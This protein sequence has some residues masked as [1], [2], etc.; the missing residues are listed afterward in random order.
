MSKFDELTESVLSEKKYRQ[1]DL[2]MMRGEMEAIQKILNSIEKITSGIHEADKELSWLSR[3]VNPLPLSKGKLTKKISSLASQASKLSAAL[4]KYRDDLE[5][6]FGD[7]ED[8]EIEIDAK[9]K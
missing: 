7:V 4:D 8:Q 3:N 5:I 9:Y 1:E 2:P 6:A